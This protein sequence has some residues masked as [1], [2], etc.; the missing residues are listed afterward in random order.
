MTTIQW[1][2]HDWVLLPERAVFWPSQSMLLVADLH[3]GKDATFRAAGIP[4]PLGSD[5]ATLDRLASVLEKV[6]PRTLAI[7]GDLFHGK[8]ADV[9]GF[10]W[11]VET[12]C[13]CE[14]ILVTGNHDRWVR[15]E[16]LGLGSWSSFEVDGINL[17]HHPSEEGEEPVICGHVHPGFIAHSG[18][19][20]TDKLPC[21]WIQKTNFVLPAFGEFTGLYMVD[22][23]KPDLVFV[24][25]GKHVFHIPSIR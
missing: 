7:L 8:Q 9:E 16:E 25:A 19:R 10:R 12:Y 15:I 4:I 11:W 5:V 13:R 24:V 21:F 23:R 1:H 22:N 2:G 18:S 14:I 20:R 3:L 6:K 17:A